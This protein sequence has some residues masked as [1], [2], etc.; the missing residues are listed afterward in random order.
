MKTNVLKKK[1]LGEN[2]TILEMSSSK[3]SKWK[4]KLDNHQDKFIHRSAERWHRPRKGS[5]LS[6]EELLYRN[7]TIM[8]HISLYCTSISNYQID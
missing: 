8:K 3:K 2:L 1:F 5:G 7:Y 6:P 4:Q